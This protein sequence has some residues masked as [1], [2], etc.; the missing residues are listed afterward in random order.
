MTR[1][2]QTKLEIERGKMVL[3]RTAMAPV[4][5]EHIKDSIAPNKQLVRWIELADEATNG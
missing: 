2:E 5:R 4:F 1:A 3:A